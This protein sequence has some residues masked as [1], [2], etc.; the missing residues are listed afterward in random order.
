MVP[1][2]GRSSPPG[3]FYITNITCGNNTL[4]SCTS[5]DVYSDECLNGDLEYTVQCYNIRS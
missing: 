4:E 2:S 5:V 1:F 3:T